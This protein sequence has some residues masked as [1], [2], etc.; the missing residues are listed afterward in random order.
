MTNA[1]Q[2]DCEDSANPMSE[3]VVRMKLT[4]HATREI[5]AKNTHHELEPLRAAVAVIPSN[6]TLIDCVPATLILPDPLSKLRC[7][8]GRSG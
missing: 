6:R 5:H 7:P 3:I 4:G 1:E 8:P 2:N